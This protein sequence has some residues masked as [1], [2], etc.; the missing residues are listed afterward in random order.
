MRGHITGQQPFPGIEKRYVSPT[1]WQIREDFHRLMQEEL[2]G[3]KDGLDEELLTRVEGRVSNRYLLGTLAPKNTHAPLEDEMQADDVESTEASEEPADEMPRPAADSMLS[4]AIGMTF[5]VDADTDLIRMSFRWGVYRKQHSE[6]GFTTEKR[7][8]PAMVWKRTQYEASLTFDLRQPVD[9]APHEDFPLVRFRAR[10]LEVDGGTRMV[11]VFLENAQDGKDAKDEAW[12]FQVYM[13]ASH[14]AGRACF[15]SRRLR[16]S[17]DGEDPLTQRLEDHLGLL[18]RKEVEFAI[19][20]GASVDWKVSED[21]RRATRIWTDPMP[22]YEVRKAKARSV[23]KVETRMAVLGSA[24]RDELRQMLAPIVPEYRAWIEEQRGKLSDSAEMVET[25]RDL[26]AA[27]A[28]LLECENAA[29]RLQQGIE[30]LTDD[31]DTNA[32]EAFCFA[33]RVMHAQRLHQL[34]AIKRKQVET[35]NATLAEIEAK[36]T[37]GWRL[38][39]LAFILISLPSLTKLDHPERCESGSVTSGP[40]AELLWFSTGGGKTEAY[41]GLTAYTLALRRLQGN[42]EGRDGEN[43]VAVLMRYTLRLLTLQQFQRATTL[44]CAC[45]VER[46]KEPKRW[47]HTP[48]R[49][50]L[51]VG[52][53][54]TPNT[55]QQ[56]V[57]LLNA[58]RTGRGAGGRGTLKQITTCPWCGSEIALGRDVEA[59]RIR[60]RILFYCGDPMGRCNFS[61]RN[62][63]GEGIPIVVVDEEVYRLLPSLVISTVDKFAQ[64]PWNGETALLFGRVTRKCPRHGYLCP[65]SDHP[66]D[67]HVARNGYPKAEVRDVD[68]LRPPDLI[69]QDELHLISGPLGS[70]V[71]LYETAVDQLCSWEVAGKTVRPKLILSTATIKRAHIQVEKLFARR[72]K[73]FPPRAINSDDT[74][75]AREDAVSEQAPGLR[76]V[77]VCAYGRRLKTTQIRVYIAALC[78]AQTLAKLYPDK[79]D[80]LMTLVGYFASL[81]ELGSMRRLLE[82]DVKNRCRSME[83]RGLEPRKGISVEELTSRRR[84]ADIPQILTRLEAKCPDDYEARR[85]MGVWP[86]DVL[87]ATNMISVGVDVPRLGLMV[88]TGQPKSTSEYIQATSRVGRDSPGIVFT[89]FNYSRPRDVSHYESFRG[90]HSAYHM[91]VENPSVTPFSAGAVDRG[92]SAV[93]VSLARLQDTDL[94]PDRGAQSAPSR[95][96]VLDEARGVIRARAERCAADASETNHASDGAQKR[97]DRWIRRAHE[98]QAQAAALNYRKPEANRVPLLCPAGNGAWKLFTC[99]NSLRGVE[100]SSHLVLLDSFEGEESGAEENE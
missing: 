95:A 21:L 14:P 54:S 57:E 31:A 94:N 88:V 56:A 34:W 82:D 69:I 18:Y 25:N 4:T 77:G 64:M 8:D 50:G 33:N 42:I 13:E 45:E 27:R 86:I 75:F 9:L 58:E 38:F 6:L 73:V 65:D 100:Q 97:V 23:T 1:P 46:R 43:G 84:A 89:V 92:L 28:A 60:E 35:R 90:Y 80:Q 41:L 19:G 48:F 40:T 66:E 81:R 12:L 63:K 52:M 99:L 71:G 61:K 7:G 70:L 39:Q 10:S 32:Y 93:L 2:V 53:A 59:D 55:V 67:A 5:C 30:L 44:I 3:P 76:Y 91:H 78:A 72:L 37:P 17:A 87:I 51:W 24:S 79:A 49:I 85:K 83:V 29:Q 20:H 74:F 62:A 22:C 96:T 15:I 47:G 68:P 98:L 26:D 11:S 36:E 16:H